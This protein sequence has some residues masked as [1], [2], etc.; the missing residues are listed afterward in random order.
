MN[1]EE[2]KSKS[3]DE[4]QKLLLDTRKAQ[5]NL[6]FQRSGG[7]LEKTSEIRKTR[8]TIAQIKTLLTVKKKAETAGEKPAAPKKKATPAKTKKKA[9]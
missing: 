5:M 1:T 9:A 3:V 6:R 7:Q 4:L 2:L 8:R